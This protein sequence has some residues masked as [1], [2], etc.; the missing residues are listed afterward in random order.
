MR[1]HDPET[2]QAVTRSSNAAAP[3]K[4]PMIDTTARYTQNLA[5][6]GARQIKMPKR[7]R[8]PERDRPSGSKVANWRCVQHEAIARAQF[9]LSCA[10]QWQ[11]G[12]ACVAAKRA[13]AMLIPFPIPKKTLRSV[14]FPSSET[15]AD[16]PASQPQT[17]E[18]KFIRSRSARRDGSNN[19]MCH[20]PFSD[21]LLR[22]WSHHEG[23]FS[24]S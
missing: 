21:A 2:Q 19:R 5:G 15:C 17:C 1:R 12:N 11:P 10:F 9:W 18:R 16:W 23:L 3:I 7:K 24:E 22:F 6:A 20:Q 8:R 4:P 13:R 14:A